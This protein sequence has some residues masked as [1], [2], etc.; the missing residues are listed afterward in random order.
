MSERDDFAEK[1]CEELEHD[2]RNYKAQYEALKRRAGG[3]QGVSKAWLIG[4]LSA[5]VLTAGGSWMA[6][7]QA[8]QSRER[9]KRAE[10]ERKVD[11]LG[12]KVT[13]VEQDQRE[14][15]QD[16]REQNKKLDEI[17][18]LLRRGR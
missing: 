8:E 11:V 12:E 1:T 5:I 16:I 18:D 15:K 7:I 10:I 4:I 2:A 6:T 14:I 13:R 17:R 3:G 9:E